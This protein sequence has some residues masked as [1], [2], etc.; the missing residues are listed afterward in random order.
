VEGR[1]AFARGEYA[2][3]LNL[4]YRESRTERRVLGE[5]SRGASPSRAVRAIE[6]GETEFFLTA[7]QSAVFNEVLSQRIR[8]GSMGSL[9]PGD[10]AFKHDNRA[11]FDVTGD[12]LGDELTGRL[13]R[14]EVSPSGPMWGA[15]M[16]RASGSPG[17]V[18]EGALA[19]AGVSLEALTAFQERRRGRL[20]GERRPLRVPLTDA[21]VEG[22]TDEHGHY[23][24]VAFDL[25]RGAFATSAIREITKADVS[26]LPEEPAEGDEPEE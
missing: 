20:T 23:I 19:A 5:L 24:R 14:L 11:C 26:E 9:V 7:F 16:K 4:F 17:E 10:I 8:Q 12:S 1:R 21:D 3:A 13:A 6:R 15:E 25:P 22:G 2:A 18:E